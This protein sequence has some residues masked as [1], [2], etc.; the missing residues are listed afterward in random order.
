MLGVHL[1]QVQAYLQP[2]LKMILIHDRI[3]VCF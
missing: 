1:Q 3:S 2:S